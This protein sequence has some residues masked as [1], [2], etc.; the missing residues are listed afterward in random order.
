RLYK[1]SMPW[2]LEPDGVRHFSEGLEEV[3]VVEEKRE[4]IENQI[5]QQLFNWRADVRPLVVGK[6]DEKG[7]WLLHPE[8]DLTVGEVAHVIAARLARFYDSDRMR[9]R[10]AYFTARETAYK[11]FRSPVDRKP[12]FCSGCPHNTSTKVPD[13][14]RALAGI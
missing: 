1:V 3:L 5:K 9:E 10:L 6:V 8:N 2:P 13:G 7:Q 4:L 11:T 14:S 12:Y